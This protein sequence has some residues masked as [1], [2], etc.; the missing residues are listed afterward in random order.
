MKKKL[1]GMATL[2]VVGLVALAIGTI[3]GAQFNSAQLS[4][5]GDFEV[6]DLPDGVIAADSCDADSTCEVNALSVGE[7]PVQTETTEGSL[8]VENNVNV[9]GSFH[10]SSGSFNSLTIDDGGMNVEEDV[11]IGGN[12]DLFG[13]IE[14]GSVDADDLEVNSGPVVLHHLSGNGSAYACIDSDGYLFRSQTPCV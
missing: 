11:T 14:A 12:I 13:E 7:Y 5:R 2:V 4:P 10:A 1:F 6:G 9:G 3:A 8:F